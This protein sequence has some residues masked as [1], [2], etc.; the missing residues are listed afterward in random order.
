MGANAVNTMAEAIA[1]RIAEIAGARTLLRILTNKAELRLTRARAVFDAELLGGEQ[2]V[3]DIVAASAFAEADP[4]RAATHNKGIMNGITAVVLATGNDTRAVEAGCHS[5]AARSGQYAALSRFEKDADGNLVGTLEVPLAVGLV[6]GATR[7]HPT[8]QASVK[9]LG[10]ETARELAS[11]IASVGLA[12]NLAACRALAAE[13][14]Q[15]GHM[16]LHAR[17]IAASAGA[18]VDEIGAV[19]ARIVADRKIRVEHARDVLAE[20]R[21][22]GE[23]A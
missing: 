3:D 22:G 10:V 23:S 17:T 7:A 20:L 4:Y 16:T 6:G 15:R 14:I 12:Q 21:S 8:A 11:V 2:V 13:G 18:E 5:H 1:P 9:L 19:A